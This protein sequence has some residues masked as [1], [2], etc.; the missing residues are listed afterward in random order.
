MRM[1]ITIDWVR[2]FSQMG[3]FLS[4]PEQILLVSGALGHVNAVRVFPDV[5][6]QPLSCT[7]KSV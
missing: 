1:W 3:T 4:C 6:R 7:V 5:S 2:F